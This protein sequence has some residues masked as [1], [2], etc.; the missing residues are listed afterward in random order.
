MKNVFLLLGFVLF[1]FTATAQ[2]IYNDFDDNQN[3]AISGFPNVPSVIANPDVSGINTSANVGEWVRTQE[4]YAHIFTELDG[5]IDFSGEDVFSLK[6]WSPITCDV[7]F[8][9]EDQNNSGVFT[10][11]MQ[12]VN[13]ANQWVELT[14]NFAGAASGTYDKIVIFFDF[15]STTDNTF[16]F[17]ELTGPAVGGPGPE[18]IILPVTFDDDEAEYGLIDFGGNFSEIVVDPTNAENMVVKTIKTTGSEIWAGTTVG[19]TIGFAY[20]IP[21]EEGSTSMFVDVWSPTAGT[22][23]RLKVE[24]AADPTISVETETLTTVAQEWETLTFDFSNE[25]PGTAEL[26]FDYNYNKASIFFDFGT[27]GSDQT[28]YWDNMDFDGELPV[29]K[30][31]L[32]IDVQDNFEDDGYGT[33]PQWNFQDPDLVELPIIIDPLNSENHV[34]DYIRSGTFEWTNAQFILD[35]RMDLTERNVFEIKVYFPSSNNY[36][37]GLLQKA[38]IKLQNSLLGGNAYTTQ[39]EI[40]QDVEILDEWVTLEFDFS[41][42]SDRTDYDQVVVQFGGEGHF[43]AGQFHFDDIR[44]LGDPISVDSKKIESLSINPNPANDII[45]IANYQSLSSLEI[46]NMNGQKVMAFDIV[47]QQISVSSLPKGV[48][49]IMANGINGDIFNTK[50]IVH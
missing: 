8:K 7:L 21:F 37:G 28:Y 30:P 24:D 34:A 13:V 1:A 6:V 26:N 48:Y 36:S 15:A 17:D 46:F 25:V 10:E 40:I 49:M 12:S 41:D 3:E 33:I 50:L 23:I 44:L 47:T 32:A 16:Y 42:V 35:H 22:P 43:G 5:K 29:V 45:S 11:V 14:Y 20:A 2:Y 31:L 39:T 18:P 4:Q 19:G 9:L 38:A 27:S